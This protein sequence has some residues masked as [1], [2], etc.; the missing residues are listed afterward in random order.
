MQAE[1]SIWGMIGL[2]LAYHA[3]GRK[4][5]SDATL[6]ALI[7]KYEKGAPY[8]IA[9]IFAYRNEVDLAFE[10]LDKAEEYKDTGLTD[11]INDHL[12]SNLHEDPRW[13]PFLE[14]IGYAPAQL[15][16]IEFKVTLP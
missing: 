14:R 3:L 7:E 13:L 4:D 15:A 2:P 10:W 5:D 16:T 11:I 1:K 6:A 8:N 12:F 9:Y